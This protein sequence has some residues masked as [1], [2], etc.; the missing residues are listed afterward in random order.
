[1]ANEFGFVSIRVTQSLIASFLLNSW[2]SPVV[3]ISKLILRLIRLYRKVGV[4]DWCKEMLR[5]VIALH[6]CIEQKVIETRRFKNKTTEM[7]CEH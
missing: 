1:M 5:K 4:S 7:Q 6:Y 2:L 3:L